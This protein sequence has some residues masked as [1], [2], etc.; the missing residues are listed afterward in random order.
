MESKGMTRFLPV[1]L[2]IVDLDNTLYDWVGFF[3]PS[4][5]AMVTAAVRIVDTSRDALLDD[6]QQV[7]QRYGNTEHPFA[8]LETEAVR[9]RF[10]YDVSR[11]E[12]KAELQP[13]F[14]AFD[15]QRI[16]KLCPVSYTHLTLP[17]KA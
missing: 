8:L 7:H 1:G 12:L 2:V 16:D 15:A 3:A 13:A 9:Q 10:G 14:D 17:T 6:I 11:G 5:E 4:F